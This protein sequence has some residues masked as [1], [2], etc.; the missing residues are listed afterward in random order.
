[1]LSTF[2]A[3]IRQPLDGG[4]LVRWEGLSVDP[5]EHVYGLP[6]PQALHGLDRHP[7]P[8][9]VR[10]ER[11]AEAGEVKQAVRQRAADLQKREKAVQ[12]ALAGLKQIK[13][14]GA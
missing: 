1:L 3:E 14:L 12:Q 7:G 4:A 10:C 8:K 5:Q 2:D 13:N 6:P 11:V 9:E